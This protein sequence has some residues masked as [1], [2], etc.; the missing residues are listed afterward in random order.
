MPSFL[1][2]DFGLFRHEFEDPFYSQDTQDTENIPLEST[3]PS[4]DTRNSYHQSWGVPSIYGS[5]ANFNLHNDEENP[6]VPDID[7]KYKFR[8]STTSTPSLYGSTAAGSVAALSR[9]SSDE[10]PPVPNIPAAYVK[11]ASPPVGAPAGPPLSQPASQDKDDKILVKWEDGEKGNPFNWSNRKKGWITF[12]LGMLALCASMGSSIIAPA[13]DAIAIYTGISHEV[14]VLCISLYIAGFA[15]GPLIWAPVSEIWGRRV[16]MLPAMLGLALFSMG[17]GFATNAQTIFITRFFAGVFG[18]APVSNVSAALGDMYLPKARGT[19]V[20]FYA[21]AVVGGPTIGPVI[22][23]AITV[24]YQLGWRW[25]MWILAMWTVV[26]WFVAFLGFP[27]TYAPYL[28]KKKAQQLRKETGDS[29]YYHPHE[30][31]KLD[32][33]SMVTKHFSRPL[34]ML[35]TEPIVT[36]IALYASFVYGLLYMSLEVFQIVFAQNRHWSLVVST[37]PFLA[38][39]VGVL[40]AAL[41]NL[42]NQPRY[43]RAMAKSRGRPVP[44]A[45]LLPMAIG[46]FLFT[47]GLFWFGWTAAPSIPW[48]VPVIA[49]GFIGAGFNVIFQQC[50]N[51]LVDSYLM[52]AASAVSAN[53][54]LR[55][56]IAAG[57]PLAARPMFSALGVGVS[58]SI[59]G[60]VAALALPVPFILMKYG[61]ALRKKS[62]F[63][64]SGPPGGGPPGGGPP[65]SGPPGGMGRGGGGPP[66]GPPGGM[67][68]GG[69]PPGGPPGASGMGRGKPPGVDAGPSG[70]GRGK[71]AEMGGGPPTGRGDGPPPFARPVAAGGSGPPTHNGPPPFVR[72]AAA[73]GSG[74]PSPYEAPPFARSGAAGGSGPPSPYGPPH[75]AR[76]GTAG[77]SGP[78]SPYGPP[79]SARA[80]AAGGSWLPTPTGPQGPRRPTGN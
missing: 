74:P 26:V 57:L 49:A 6:P 34:R 7:E 43:G 47:I 46:G 76:A 70:M 65:G 73:G 35:F 54:I 4:F 63:A 50:I 53:T 21:I 51:F 66:G 15:F 8:R 67:G 52:Y 75:F 22:G 29:R 23:S 17:T 36:C 78:P 37:L 48:I 55:S 31:T 11:P 5:T 71:P 59:L 44:E 77:G 41:I 68:R 79:Q 9:H 62:N 69:G 58:M 27:E 12:E 38:L 40:F 24:N 13:E 18:S 60:G 19:A 20:T 2:D 64:P 61:V 72:S 1:G 14:A 56:F 39:F 3:R 30:E 25:V 42:A 80:G 33:K 28:L 16:S 10:K 32:V 45:R